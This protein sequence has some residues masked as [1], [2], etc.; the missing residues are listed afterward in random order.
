[1]N[2]PVEKTA[3][4]PNLSTKAPEISPDAKR[5]IAKAETIKPIAALFTPND[6]AKTGIA[7]MTIP[8]PTATKKDAAIRIDTSRGRSLKGERIKL[9]ILLPLLHVLLHNL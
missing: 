4:S 9:E 2:T 5:V 1:M 8:K 6:L 3:L 7:G